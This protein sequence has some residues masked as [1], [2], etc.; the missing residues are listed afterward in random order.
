MIVVNE[1]SNSL[2]VTRAASRK[3]WWGQALIPASAFSLR[4]GAGLALALAAAAPVAEASPP[5]IAL[6]QPFLTNQVLIH[7][8]TEANRTYALQYTSSLSTNGASSGPWSN[9]YVAPLLPFPNHYVIVD[10]RTNRMRFYRL[11]ATP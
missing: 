9:V 6:I 7:F 10:Y 2:S 5:Q 3:W 4:L 11:Q 1:T 8:D